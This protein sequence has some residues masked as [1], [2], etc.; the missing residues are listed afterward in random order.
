MLIKTIT[1][2]FN[3]T[4]G[5]FDDGIV[6]EFIKDKEIISITNFHFVRNEIP[7][8]TFVLTY[9]P[10]RPESNPD[11]Q[12]PDPWRKSLNE[13]DYGLFNLLRDWR[14]DTAKK[15]AKPPYVVFRNEVLA[16][17]V[18]RRPQSK[19]ELMKINGIGTAKAA[20]YGDA[21]LKIIG[22]EPATSEGRDELTSKA[23]ASN[24]PQTPSDGDG[25]SSLQLDTKAEDNNS[26]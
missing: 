10:Y 23:E 18:Q 13:A 24:P 12:K 15:K 1:L 4:A 21:I 22:V 8:L 5:E 9:Y 3:S 11:A 16:E 26:E 6:R 14:N 20:E 19:A 17:I 2:T 25:Q 7:Y